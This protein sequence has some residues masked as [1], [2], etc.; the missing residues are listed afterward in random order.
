MNSA[1]TTA[2][3]AASV[4]EIVVST[5]E[6]AR[7]VRQLQEMVAQLRLEPEVETEIQVKPFDLRK[8]A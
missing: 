2:R 3:M 5:E 6:L 8:A 7:I 1:E 4:K